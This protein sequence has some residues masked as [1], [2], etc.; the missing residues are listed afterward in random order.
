MTLYLA[1]KIIKNNIYKLKLSI[2][3]QLKYLD[4]NYVNI[5]YI[6]KKTQ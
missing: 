2:F 1:L 5:I 4:I 6:I 3:R